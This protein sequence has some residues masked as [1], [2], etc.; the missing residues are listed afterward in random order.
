MENEI[1]QQILNEL[2]DLKQGQQQTNQ[3]LDNLEQRQINLEKG[4]I[5]L[6]RGQNNLEQGQHNLERG[7]KDL[8]RGQKDLEQ[9]QQQ[10]NQRLDNL[11]QDVASVKQIALKIEIEHG[12]KLSALFDS[13]SMMYD[14]TKDLRKDIVVLQGEQERH[15]LNIKWLN[16]QEKAE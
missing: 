14:I 9:G 10:I 1:L 13:Y 11:E 3:R 15:E 2:K 16:L 4:Q 5:S 12:Q 8:E 6:E 7:Q